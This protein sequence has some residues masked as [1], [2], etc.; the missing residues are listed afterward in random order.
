MN[1]EDGLPFRADFAQRVLETADRITTRRRRARHAAVAATVLL[2]AGA[3]TLGALR[4]A[5]A[6]TPVA[7]NT[8][9]LV[10]SFEVVATDDTSTAPTDYLFP[11][12]ADLTQF[13]EDY[14][15]TAT[16]DDER[17][18]FADEEDEGNASD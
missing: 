6:R 18:L 14:A 3:G 2:F 16:R 5:P 1:H 13:S 12:A 7:D 17:V 15:G 10:T 8:P 4:I 11:E 9:H